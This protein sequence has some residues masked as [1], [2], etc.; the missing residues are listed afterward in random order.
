MTGL[1]LLA[2]LTAS[3]LPA[4]SADVAGAPGM[5]APDARVV[6]P[7]PSAQ[8]DARPLSQD[9]VGRTIHGR[10]LS[11]DTGTP[12]PYARVE[13]GSGAEV[14]ATVADAE[15]RYV[16]EDVAAG[17]Q[18]VRVSTLDHEPLEVFVEIP[19]S[20][21]LALDL[22]L[23]LDPVE[24]RGITVISRPLPGTRLGPDGEPVA[25]GSPGDP[26]LRALEATPGVAE[27]GLADG[28]RSE[29]YID[30]N[31]PESVLYVRGA[32]SDLK[33]V[34]LDGAPV[35]APF[36]LGGLLDA[37]QPGV[38]RSAWL[39]YGGAPARYDGGLSYVLDLRTRPGRIDG[40]HSS[41]ALDLLGFGARIEGPV[42]TGSFLAGGRVMHRAGTDGFTGEPLPYG[43]ADALA[44]LDIGL[45][46]G[47]YLS[48]TGFFNRE[49]VDLAGV[50]LLDGPAYWGNTAGS[51]R[52]GGTVAGSEAEFVAALARFTTRL[53]VGVEAPG[54][55]YGKSLRARLAA[56][57]TRRVGAVHLGYGASYDR[58]HIDYRAVEV[59]DSGSVW[60]HRQGEAD[61]AGTY[62]EV[63]WEPARDLKV[64]GGLRA[65]L[66]LSASRVRLAPRLSLLWQ[67]SESS[68][69][70]VAGGR[71]YQYLRIPET[72]L[73]GNLSDA[74][75]DVLAGEVGMYSPTASPL[76]VAGATHLAVGLTHIPR[77]SLRLGMEAFYKA[78]DGSPELEG[79]R[80]SGIDLWIDF[81]DGPWAAW[82][83]YSLAWAWSQRGE[84]TVTNRFSARHLLSGGLSAP[85]PS[86][87]RFDARLAS[88]YGIPYT[89]IPTGRTE[90]AFPEADRETLQRGADRL[91]AGAPDGS[92]LR[93]D[94]QIS[95]SWTA[96]LFGSEIEIMPYLKLLNALDRR[97]ALFYQ[98]DAGHDLRPRSLQAVPLLPVI[99]IAWNQ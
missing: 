92:Y 47:H 42:A 80:A 46:A 71:Y 82:A 99:G 45:G 63:I 62:G 40:F 84:Q 30:P 87:V 38:L 51:L 54:V 41:G 90:S 93:L 74:W 57:F 88:S 22:A 94:A 76:A 60:L 13:V 50:T 91:L 4:H 61:A 18:R 58:Q 10:V 95:R 98:F 24:L 89:P 27:F 96:R 55:A 12:L 19:E 33:L 75:T 66:F 32:A 23:R 59:S 16:L 97:D 5:V 31:D 35:Y 77:P 49:S 2:V 3:G 72:I 67:V 48:A 8:A 78:F 7:A 56:N 9:T 53:P 15:G 43:Y 17:R 28:A 37:F 39:Y 21:E 86:G 64:Q 29:P 85:L 79:L 81:G 73:S 14:R 6:R 34:L 44:R 83:G 52:Y 65:N 1:F 70:S 36:H 20:G 11:E 68:T 25:R 69:L 26:E